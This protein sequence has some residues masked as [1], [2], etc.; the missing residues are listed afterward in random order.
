MIIKG[1]SLISATEAFNGFPTTNSFTEDEI[2][3]P[4]NSSETL[5]HNVDL[6]TYCYILP[7]VC[8]FGII[9]NV[10]NLFTLASPRLKSVSYMYLRALALSDLLCMI[11]VLFFS[12]AQS[13]EQTLT[14][15]WL[16][17]FY[18]AHIM[19]PLINWALATGVL[20]VV[21]LS[22]ERFTS[23]VFPM[24]FRAWTSTQRAKRAIA[25]AYIIPALMYIPYGIG[26]HTIVE[27]KASDDTTIFSFNDSEIS[28]TAKWKA[29]KWTRE[30][31]LRF[32]PI[33]IVSLLNMQIMT[34]FRK[35]KRTFRRLTKRKESSTIKEDTLVYI[36]G[37]IVAMFFICN[38]P[39]AM[40]L[41]FI[42]ETVKKRKDYQIFRAVANLLEIINHASQFYV[43]CVCSTDYRT[44]FL[45][46]FSCF[47]SPNNQR[48]RIRSLLKQKSANIVTAS[49]TNISENDLTITRKPS[50]SKQIISER[51]VGTVSN[52]QNICLTSSADD[53]LC[54]DES[55][56][57][58]AS[59]LGF[60]TANEITY[61]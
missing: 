22:L 32:A 9:G 31:L 50:S 12:I 41:L 8:T 28:T 39:A 43:F 42:N 47:K 30:G 36:L 55:E 57:Q 34:A 37:G 44:T 29:Y 46:K 19:L 27:N 26:R 14:K 23:V 5:S 4:I 40:N 52:D 48:K 18:E 59:E 56:L 21:E 61:L 60:S 51:K 49:S 17:A 25:F 10:T 58:N 53:I 11:F 45:Q 6:I 54:G 38:I 33:I 7:A 16:F 3:D 15:S 13:Q 35:R 2:V 20:I 24:H 1:D